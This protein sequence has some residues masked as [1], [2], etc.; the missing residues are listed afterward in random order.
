MCKEPKHDFSELCWIKSVLFALKFHKYM[1]KISCFIETADT[2]AHHHSSL[3]FLTLP[4]GRNLEQ[5][6][7]IQLF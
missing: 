7:K 1:F 3:I 4:G 5:T 2:P 6:S